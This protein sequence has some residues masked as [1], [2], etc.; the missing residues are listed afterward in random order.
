MLHTSG[1]ICQYMSTGT[2]DLHL[3]SGPVICMCL[4]L[5]SCAENSPTGAW[6]CQPTLA[7]WHLRHIFVHALMSALIYDQINLSV[8]KCMDA[9]APGCDKLCNAVKMS[10]H[11]D[12]GMYRHNLPVLVSQIYFFCTVGDNW[13]LLAAMQCFSPVEGNGGAHPFVVPWKRCGYW[14]FQ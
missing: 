9:L 8:N 12:A 2:I 13:S 7:L 10:L 6:V 3:G 14:R 1:R 11:K 5:S 4:N